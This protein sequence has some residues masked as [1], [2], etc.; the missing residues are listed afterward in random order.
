MCQVFVCILL[1]AHFPLQVERL[2]HIAVATA[3]VDE[4]GVAAGCHLLLM[5]LLQ[6]KGTLQ[7]LIRQ[8]N[9][10]EGEFG[11]R[12]VDE[13]TRAQGAT[14]KTDVSYL[15]STESLDGLFENKTDWLVLRFQFS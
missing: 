15:L 8:Q 4:G 9:S 5:L 10:Q 3:Q 2:L 11:T 14:T 7:I 1:H 12:Q 6:L 13:A